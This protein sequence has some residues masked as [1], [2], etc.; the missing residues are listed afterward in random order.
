M[1]RF[2]R[3]F[4]GIFGIF[5]SLLLYVFLSELGRD[6][7]SSSPLA[8]AACGSPPEVKAGNPVTLRVSRSNNSPSSL[9]CVWV[10]NGTTQIVAYNYMGG[11]V[12]L[13]R[14]WL[15]IF[16]LPYYRFK[17]LLSLVTPVMLSSSV[18]Y[19]GQSKLIW[20]SPSSYD[21]LLPGSYRLRLKYHVENEESSQTV[22][23][24]EFSPS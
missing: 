17:S 3:F 5:F 10:D 23:T 21:S 2:I 11:N 8:R 13:E 24:E 14:K 18:V 4:V 9:A 22:Y 6:P 19:P 15:K 7:I 12:Q 16:W 1:R 20:V